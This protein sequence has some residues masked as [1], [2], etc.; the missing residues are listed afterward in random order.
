MDEPMVWNSLEEAAVWLASAT[1][2]AWTARQVLSAEIKLAQSYQSGGKTHIK[3]VMPRNTSFGYYQ[4]QIGK[5][6]T[7]NPFI[8]KS[9]APWMNIPLAIPH[10]YSLL[11][12]EETR[13]GLV[14]APDDEDG[15]EGEYIFLD[16]IEQEHVISIKFAGITGRDLKS[17]LHYLQEKS[18]V[19][20]QHEEEKALTPNER[21]SMLKMIISMAVKGYRYDPAATKNDAV[22]EITKDMEELGITLSDDTVRKYL[23]LAATKLP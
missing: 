19:S 7:K 12:H 18:P 2:K 4:P 6:A 11:I 15:R 8:R 5:D 17:L 3:A 13:V 16:P 14:R 23:K 10:L 9:N 22:V 1:N 20:T 21:S